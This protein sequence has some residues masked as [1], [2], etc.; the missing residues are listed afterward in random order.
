MIGPVE[1][2]NQ[3]RDRIALE[4][5][6]IMLADSPLPVPSTVASRAYQVAACMMDESKQWEGKWERQRKEAS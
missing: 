3:Q 5:L 2:I 1:T 4:V 6:K